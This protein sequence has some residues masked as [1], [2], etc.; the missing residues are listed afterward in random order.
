MQARRAA[1]AISLTMLA[2]APALRAERASLQEAQTVAENYISLILAKD[3][4]WGGSTKATVRTIQELKR[5]ERTLGYICQVEPQGFIIV[6]LHKELA[7]IKAYSVDSNL[8]PNLD[9]G[10]TDVIKLSMERILDAVENQRGK[11]I[12]PT[13]RFDDLL[14]TQ[15]RPAWNELA[16]KGFDATA[17]DRSKRLRSIGMNYQEGEVLLKDAWGQGAPYNDQ[18]PYPMV[19]DPGAGGWVQSECPSQRNGRKIVGCV[20]TAGS[21]IMHHWRWPPYGEGGSPYSDSYDWRNMRDEYWWNEDLDCYVDENGTPLTQVH[22][23]A[24]AELSHEV[25]LAVGMDYGCD[26]STATVSDMEDVFQDAFRYALACEV[27]DRNDFTSFEWFDLMKEDIS[28]NRPIEV[29]VT[30]HAIV[31]DGWK[32]EQ[33]GGEVYWYHLNYGWRGI[34]FDPS[35]PEWDGYTS[36]NAWFALDAH[37]LG[38]VDGDYMLRRTYPKFSIGGW[39]E[40]HYD[41]PSPTLTRYFDQDARGENATFDAGIWYQALEPG[42]IVRNEGTTSEAITFN[43]APGAESIFFFYGD[44]DAYTRVRIKDGTIKLRGGGEMVIH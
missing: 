25:G 7:P 3:G 16:D 32:E 4:N 27:L 19:W 26:S 41:V 22:I 10:M 15:Y 35:D 34:G 5:N 6:S 39:I 37:P 40:G 21:Q 12:E 20:A 2:S 11:T 18:C 23:D 43:G 44:I 36:S 17:Y 13:A 9:I 14:E 8:D 1:L 31:A 28:R 30:G 38:D 42:L 24:V 29:H 33:I